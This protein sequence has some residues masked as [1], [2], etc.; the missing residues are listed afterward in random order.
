[1]HQMLTQ[2]EMRRRMGE[3]ARARM[4]RDHRLD[5][6]LDALGDR[7]RRITQPSTALD[8]ARATRAAAPSRKR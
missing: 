7:M 6:Q 4:V 1:M 3:Q 8:A 2:P 5:R